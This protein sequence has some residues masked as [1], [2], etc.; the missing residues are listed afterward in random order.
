MADP[1]KLLILEDNPSD[2]ELM[3]A[4]LRR[5]GYA[6]DWRRV[7]D[8]REFAAALRPDLDVILADYSLPGYDALRALAEVQRKAP[9]VPFVVVTGAVSEEVAVECMKRG[10]ADYLLKDR[11][12]R[13]G[14]AVAHALEQRRLAEKERRAERALRRTEERHRL[15]M[16]NVRDYAIFF[17]DPAGRVT[18]WN[19][20][21]QRIFGYAEP[22]ILGSHFSRFFTAEE[23]AAGCPD[24]ELREAV[25]Q[26]RAE[27]ERWHVRKD[28]SRFW[29]S[30]ITNALRDESGVLRGFAK[31]ARDNTE[32]KRMEEERERLLVREQASRQAAEEARRRAEEAQRHAE[33]ARR[34][35]EVADRLKDEFLAT[36]SHELRTP[37]NA[38]V[39]WAGMLCEGGFSPQAT[40]QAMSII[41][42][43]AEAQAQLVNDLLDVSRIVSGKLRLKRRP[44]SLAALVVAAVD[45]VRPAAAAK[46]IALQMTFAEGAD[47]LF[48]DPD[49]MQ[50]VFWNL[51]IN[52]VKFTPAGGRVSVR[53]AGS[54]NG[55]T[56]TVSDTGEGISPD[57]LPHL[58]ERF[59]QADGS[60]TRRHGGLGLGLAI[61][62]HLVEAH[63]GSVRAESDGPGKGATFTVALPFGTPET[64][65][66]M[67]GQGKSISAGTAPSFSGRR[68]LVVD[69][70]A[71][72]RELVSLILRS[73][74]ADVMVASSAPEAL[75]ALRLARPDALVSDI[76]MPGQDGCDLIRAIRAAEPNGVSPL[77]ALALTAY[78][79]EEDRERAL[80]AGFQ[81]FVAKPIG[82]NELTAAVAGLLG[83]LAPQSG[84]NLPVAAK[85][86]CS[87]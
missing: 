26:G 86:N 12:T 67:E 16:E 17:M 2:A 56:V 38:I 23:A 51:L 30:G 1:I 68:L 39:G 54:G 9:D 64:P 65:E 85:D 14:Q 78:A 60:T 5:A 36:L 34:T 32:R 87:P 42:R 72:A 44:L 66:P 8:E 31:V 15:L 73:R 45:A 55:V 58:F 50:Q 46:S 59:R 28:G 41:R 13:L 83:V 24:A 52:A 7:E 69:D 84:G 40:A 74:G 25:A 21:S 77:P 63:G 53:T 61:V 71:D 82:H 27:D 80:E 11:L 6:P 19:V 75:E 70:Q 79:K 29:A 37:L 35:A 33:E 48:G 22:E 43:N 76:G 20:G 47:A 3:V 57:F 62:R 49:R 81:A 18:G 10:A 4:E